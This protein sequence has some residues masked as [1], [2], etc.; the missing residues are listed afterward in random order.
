MDSRELRDSQYHRPRTKQKKKHSKKDKLPNQVQEQP[1]ESLVQ[2][3][4]NQPSF[5][6][7]ID[8]YSSSEKLE[9]ELIVQSSTS[10]NSASSVSGDLNLPH[11]SP[12]PT[13][14]LKKAAVAILSA[15]ESESESK[16]SSDNE[17]NFSDEGYQMPSDRL[18]LF[19]K[20]SI[21]R[22]S[23]KINVN[24]IHFILSDV[25]DFFYNYFFLVV[26]NDDDNDDDDVILVVAFRFL[27]CFPWLASRL[28]VALSN[29]LL[30]KEIS[31]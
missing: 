30:P 21:L 9:G 6:E 11:G 26:V 8:S 17:D 2:C 19:G 25:S 4:D 13:S 31:P 29:N 22:S 12:I 27:R 3:S 10:P 24:I 18:T 23:A 7:T 28:P 14:M 5:L 16:K 15:S 1:T 20:K